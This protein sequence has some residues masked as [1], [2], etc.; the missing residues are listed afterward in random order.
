MSSIAET[1][2]ENVL[3][4]LQA[5]PRFGGVAL[6]SIRRSHRTAIS[7]DKAPA[8]HVIDDDEVPDPVKV[9]KGCAV[10]WEKGFTVSLFLRDDE[11]Y[12]AAD[13]LK[14]EVMSRLDPETAPWPAGVVL[15]YGKIAY[16]TEIADGDAVRVDMRFTFKFQAA[17]WQLDVGAS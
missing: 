10:P 6:A 14:L 12:P 2:M 15:A 4:R 3:A 9:G 16:Q 17:S 7:R 1:C 5:A 8:I 13:P 11:G